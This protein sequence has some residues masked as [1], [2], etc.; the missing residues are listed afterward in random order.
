MKINVSSILK[1]INSSMEANGKIIVPS[2]DYKQEDI[3]VNTP[4]EV[5][6]LITNTG[7]HLLI[8]GK[9]KTDLTLKCSRCLES[10]D[11][12]LENDFEEELSN[13]DDDDDSIHFDGDV[14]D[15]TEI[16]LNN[17]V[18]SLPMKVI[19]SEECRGLCPHCGSNINTDKCGCTDEI[20]D[21]RLA[22]LK[23]LLKDN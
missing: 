7:N 17:I 10:F 20:L 13:N 19:C 18:L 1:N 11:Y 9:I 8:E 14:V 6:A 23:D 3:P 22:V 2:I 5:K 16:I 21:P 12:T 15:I 4:I